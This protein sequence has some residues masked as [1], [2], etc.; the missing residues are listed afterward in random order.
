M[1]AAMLALV[2]VLG[3]GGFVAYRV[4]Q[5]G[6]TKDA[7]TA[8]EPGKAS[9][10]ATAP[11]DAAKDAASQPGQAGTAAEAGKDLSGA[12][13]ATRPRRTTTRPRGR[14]NRSRSGWPVTRL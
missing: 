3:I 11:V 5:S 1:I 13:P 2:A 14:P 6:E 8:A 10:A 7:T 12:A 4:S 9:D